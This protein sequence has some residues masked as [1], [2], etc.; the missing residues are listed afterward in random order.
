LVKR[1]L[2][3]ADVNAIRTSIQRPS[4][5]AGSQLLR[6]SLLAGRPAWFWA[7]RS[8]K[9]VD[10]N[11]QGKSKRRIKISRGFVKMMNICR[12]VKSSKRA[13]RSAAFA[14]LLSSIFAFNGCL[15]ADFFKRTLEST[16]TYG[17]LEFLLDND[18]VFDL[19]EDGAT[20][21]NP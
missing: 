2:L 11:I 7:L 20:G 16:V 6:R 5:L 19:F 17:A 12:E 3:I 10:L 18:T 21:S 13:M 1:V 4:G 8:Q 9:W 14:V 15:S